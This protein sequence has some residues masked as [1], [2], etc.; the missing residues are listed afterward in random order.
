MAAGSYTTTVKEDF[1]P[2]GEEYMPNISQK[3]SVPSIEFTCSV[4]QIDFDYHKYL[5]VSRY[6]TEAVDTMVDALET[7]KENTLD[8]EVLAELTKCGDINVE[9]FQSSSKKDRM[10]QQEVYDA[11]TVIS[12][13][14]LTNNPFF[15]NL[16]DSHLNKNQHTKEYIVEGKRKVSREE[17]MQP[18]ALETSESDSL[19]SWI[20]K[21]RESL[22]VSVKSEVSV[23]VQTS[24][25]DDI[26]K[27]SSNELLKNVINMPSTSSSTSESGKESHD[28]FYFVNDE[29]EMVDQR[30]PSN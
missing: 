16:L 2:F 30:K 23:G 29:E 9:E 18:N 26:F 17:N 22:P 19:D 14:Q 20:F 27:D 10:T 5:I 12:G 8:V 4:H 15:Y 24:E 7:F 13:I 1:D 21:S 11:E 3:V 28:I 6:L 25:I